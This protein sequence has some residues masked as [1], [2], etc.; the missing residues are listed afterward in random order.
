MAEAFQAMTWLEKVFLTCAVVGGVL[1][2]IRMVLFL[3]GGGG[4]ADAD[5]DLDADGAVGHGP[6]SD[7]A[8]KLLSLQGLTAFLMMFG[9]VGLALL[10]ESRAAEGL[11]VAGAILA[12]LGSSWLIAKMFQAMSRLQSSGTL[13]LQNAVG[14]EGV[15]YLRIPAG[16][17]G[18]VNVTVQEH[19]H[20]FEAVADGGAEIPTGQRVRVTRVLGGNV[21]VVEKA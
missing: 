4:D 8:F 17:T 2:L 7:A 18:K 14:Q 19:L 20:T 21:L 13:D 16:G 12:G 11:A 9:I 1:F 5:L 6:D 10:R 15:V 3:F